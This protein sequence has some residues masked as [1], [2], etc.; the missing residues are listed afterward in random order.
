MTKLF[1]KKDA[2][3]RFSKR[4]QVRVTERE[5]EAIR[6]YSD[7]ASMTISDFFRKSALNQKISFRYEQKIIEEL[8]ELRLAIVTL[9]VEIKKQNLFDAEK[10]M[11]ATLVALESAVL[12]ISR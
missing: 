6:F 2:A 11:T 9:Y 3:T 1:K 10:K 12:R 8:M 5:S 4:F 7:A